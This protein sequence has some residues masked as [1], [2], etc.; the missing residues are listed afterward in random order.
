M[1][2]YVRLK[3]WI[4]NCEKADNTWNKNIGLLSK[5][6]QRCTLYGTYTDM[7]HMYARVEEKRSDGGAHGV[8]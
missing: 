3:A 2:R 1:Q 4:C 6:L 7:H 5:E 8:A